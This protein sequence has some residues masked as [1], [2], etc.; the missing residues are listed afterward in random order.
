MTGETHSA[1][2][3]AREESER[4]VSELEEFLRIRSISS[5]PSHDADIAY[6]AEWIAGRLKALGASGV[7]VVK[8]GKHPIVFGE[9]QATIDEASLMPTVLIY[10]HYDVQRPDPVE[11][12]ESEAFAPEIR[13]DELFARGAVD[14]KGPI[15][16]AIAAVESLLT[17]GDLPVNIKFM[18]EGEEEIGSP[19]LPTYLRSN[20]EILK[21]DFCLNGDSGMAAAGEPT[22]TYGLRGSIWAV[23]TISGPTTDLH[24]GLFGGTVHNPVHVL[25]D[26]ISGLH[27]A[28]GVITLPGFYDDVRPIDPEE[29]A[30]L[31]KIPRDE[32]LT[33]ALS[34][35]PELWGERSYT[36]VERTGVRPA[37]DVLM[38][39][40]GAEKTA[41][42]ASVTAHISMRLVPDQDPFW[43][44][45]Q[46]LWWCI[47]H[48][49]R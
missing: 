3:Y 13:G 48:V 34:G 16:A 9:I 19:S 36:P 24:S 2:I 40:G 10:G 12:W 1:I 47:C 26:L 38:I 31:A 49:C 11:E 43:H 39:Q 45:Q 4:Y 7:E 30:L 20:K 33:K 46:W 15:I 32:T 29:K 18:I 41:I 14:N 6:A 35:V 22:I 17:T 28:E 27:D 8:T 23:L 25:A 44:L 21:S 5:D 37:L 42:P